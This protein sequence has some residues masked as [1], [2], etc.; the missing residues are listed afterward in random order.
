MSDR[1]QRPA[2]FAAGVV[3]GNTKPQVRQPRCEHDMAGLCPWCLTAQGAARERARIVAAIRRLEAT[4]CCSG[5]IAAWIEAGE[6]EVT[7]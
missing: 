6:D 3:P 1:D 2:L 5:M 7:P 4:V